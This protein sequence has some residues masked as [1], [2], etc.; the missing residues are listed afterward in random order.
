MS[1]VDWF[2]E[3]KT[4]NTIRL[5]N[6]LV[7]GHHYFLHS[8]TSMHMFSVSTRA[9]CPCGAVRSPTPWWSLPALSAQ[10]KPSTS[11]WCPSHV[12][13]AAKPNSWWSPSVLDTSVL[14]F[15]HLDFLVEQDLSLC[16]L[17][18]G[19]YGKPDMD[20][21]RPVDTPTGFD[22]LWLINW[23]CISMLQRRIL[24]LWLWPEGY[25]HHFYFCRPVHG[26]GCYFVWTISHKVSIGTSSKF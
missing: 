11:L 14:P 1:D 10:W 18:L 23:Q 17:F 21:L 16:I 9:L 22:Q 8:L 25:C 3:Q 13:T 15:L 24:P 5:P 26:M 4:P 19:L 20:K 7:H 2:L 6:D 12:P